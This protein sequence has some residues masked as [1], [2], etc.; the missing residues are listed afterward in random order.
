MVSNSLNLV[1]GFAMS[2]HR[3]HPAQSL[4]FCWAFEITPPR[5]RYA[6]YLI[7]PNSDV[8]ALTLANLTTYHS[9]CRELC[10]IVW[11]KCKFSENAS[12]HS[13]LS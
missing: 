1:V 4:S 6:E 7:R 2:S 9:L 3:R 8:Y 10:I 13:S 12:Q 11:W 5:Q